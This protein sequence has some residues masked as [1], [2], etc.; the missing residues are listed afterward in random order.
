VFMRDMSEPG[1]WDEAMK[2]CAGVVHVASDVSYAP[3][4]NQIVTQALALVNDMLN[5]AAVTSSVKRFVYTSSQATLPGLKEPGTISGS[6][7]RPDADDLIA[8]AWA[9]PHIV[10]KGPVVYLASKVCAERACWEFVKRESPGFVFNSVLPGFNVGEVIHPQLISSSNKITVDLLDSDPFAVDFVKG[11]SPISSV[12]L[13][14]CALLHLAALTM[15]NVQNER[16]LALGE[17]FE[18]NRMVDVLASLVP[19]SNLP[20]KVDKPEI[21]HAEVDKTREL[22]LLKALG[23]TGFVGFEE[24]IRQCITTAANCN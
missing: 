9:E 22:G 21:V 8:L 4:P 2:G 15:E 24:S 16:L 13:E 11:I 6:S 20:A 1:V 19:G 17:E 23:R 7:W 10:E 12:N 18:F 14:D 5:S 3:D